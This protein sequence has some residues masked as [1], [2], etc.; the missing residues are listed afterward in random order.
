MSRRL[1]RE[2]TLVPALVIA[3]VL[4][5]AV[6]WP[7]TL[8]HALTTPW[9][10]W[11]EVPTA[12]QLAE[13]QSRARLT[14]VV[15]IPLPLLACVSAHRARMPLATALLLSGTVLAVLVSGFLAFLA[16]G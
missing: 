1:K 6:A 14:A 5:W 13:A 10:P 3:L 2:R 15:G 9:A 8:H 11:G 4:V 7:V 16:D 12:A